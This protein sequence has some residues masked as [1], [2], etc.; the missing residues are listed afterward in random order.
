VN[1]PN[2]E[3]EPDQAD[4][5]DEK[6]EPDQELVPSNSHQ[7]QVSNAAARQHPVLALYVS[8]PNLVRVIRKASLS[9]EPLD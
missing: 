1:E 4:E 9:S 6:E 5:P 7:P 2:Q 8:V 3:G